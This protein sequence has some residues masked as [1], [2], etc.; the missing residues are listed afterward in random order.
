MLF[1]RDI[2]INNEFSAPLDAVDE[3]MPSVR[4]K[5]PKISKGIKQSL[6]K[7]LSTLNIFSKDQGNKKELT[8][9]QYA[10]QKMSSL[11]L[12]KG[13][14]ILYKNKKY[15]I[16]GI[17]EVDGINGLQLQNGG[18]KFTISKTESIDHTKPCIQ[19]QCHVQK[20][21]IQTKPQEDSIHKKSRLE[22]KLLSLS[23][24]DRQNLKT[25]L[26]MNIAIRPPFD[27]LQ[28]LL[29]ARESGEGIDQK[30]FTE[31]KKQLSHLKTKLKILEKKL[32]TSAKELIDPNN[33][34]NINTKEDRE[35]VLSFLRFQTVKED[36]N[37]NKHKKSIEKFFPEDRASDELI[38]FEQK[39]NNIVSKT[40]AKIKE[41]LGTATFQMAGLKTIQ[42]TVEMLLG[43]GSQDLKILWTEGQ[44]DLSDPIPLW[45]LTFS[46]NQKITERV[47]FCIKA[48][49]AKTYLELGV[50]QMHRVC[51]VSSAL[52]TDCSVNVD[53][54]NSSLIA[55]MGAVGVIVN[56]FGINKDGLSETIQN[57]LKGDRIAS[58]GI[59]LT[60]LLQLV[61]GLMEQSD[62]LPIELQ[63]SL[64][65]LLLIAPGIVLAIAIKRGKE[66]S[67]EFLSESLDNIKNLINQL[68][69]EKAKKNIVQ[70][71]DILNDENLLKNCGAK[72]SQVLNK[73]KK[74]LEDLKEFAKTNVISQKIMQFRK[75]FKKCV[76]SQFIFL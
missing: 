15:I 16:S 48:I 4:R 34:D 59:M 64:E 5:I 1:V 46:K 30:R 57:E 67:S 20:N 71:L 56:N 12:T 24:E 76:T 66:F 55:V 17:G 2:P 68:D 65:P 50:E 14:S 63:L 49:I 19:N 45:I 31:L 36:L 26:E 51:E 43:A 32:S 6:S 73:P 61:Y 62:S 38:I 33:D 40:L 9:S 75:S 21:T 54:L 8:P 44:H 13:D 42:G 69:L 41:V 23:C 28:D 25:R 18:L 47:E 35:K 70:C 3:I 60:G 39:K 7:T 58:F 27:E 74:S 10:Q 37:T 11:N 22:K 29:I 72:C 53:M 52:A